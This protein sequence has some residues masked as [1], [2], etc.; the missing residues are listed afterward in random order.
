[1][2]REPPFIIVLDPFREEFFRETKQIRVSS[3]GFNSQRH[4]HSHL[5]FCCFYRVLRKWKRKRWVKLFLQLHKI[6]FFVDCE[7][8]SIP[9][10]FPRDA[11]HSYSIWSQIHPS[12]IA[13]P[14]KR[15][16]RSDVPHS[17][18]DT[19][20]GNDTGFPTLRKA[21]AKFVERILTGDQVQGVACKK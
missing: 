5:Y 7:N 20:H 4:R 14:P 2:D 21:A 12:R 13:C 11:F 18:P 6:P 16:T 3:S 15:M 8:S 1:M 9:A 17:Y 19:E 10:Q